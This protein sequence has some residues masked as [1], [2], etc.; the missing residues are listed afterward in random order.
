MDILRPCPRP[1]ESGLRRGVWGPAGCVLMH[2]RCP[3]EP[4]SRCPEDLGVIPSVLPSLGNGLPTPAR[5][6]NR[7]PLPCA[8]PL[9]VNLSRV[10][11]SG[12]WRALGSG[13]A[14]R[15]LCDVAW[16][17]NRTH[18]RHVAL[19]VVEA[20][21]PR[22]WCWQIWFPMTASWPVDRGLLSAPCSYKENCPID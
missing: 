7:S 13:R 18:D 20:G 21:S 8:H 11:L 5:I 9:W 2:P 4:E 3:L 1:T 22:S 14:S 19:L 6:P 16:L 10:R 17:P 15:S 12:A